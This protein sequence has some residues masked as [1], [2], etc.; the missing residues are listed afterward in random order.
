MIDVPANE[1]GVVRVF[2]VNGD[3]QGS[4]TAQSFLSRLEQDPAEVAAEAERLRKM[5]G[6][7]QIDP[8]YTET[9]AVKDI[10]ELGLSRYISTAMDVPLDTLA[11]DRARLDALEGEVLIVLSRALGY[12]GQRLAPGPDLT[13]IGAYASAEVPLS[14]PVTAPTPEPLPD[15]VQK[16]QETDPPEGTDTGRRTLIIGAALVIAVLLVLLVGG[17]N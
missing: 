5:L 4:G 15:P 7:E 16:D 11:P 9:F 14:G 1:T 13:F 12:E 8:T 10:A 3:S 6:A 2:A 17:G